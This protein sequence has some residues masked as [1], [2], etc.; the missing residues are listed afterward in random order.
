[1]RTYSLLALFLLGLNQSFTQPAVFIADS[2][3]VINHE[4]EVLAFA[5]GVPHINWGRMQFVD[6]N[7]DGVLELYIGQSNG[8]IRKYNNQGTPTQPLWVLETS[9]YGSLDVGANAAPLWADLDADGDLDMLVGH[10]SNGC[11]GGTIK[12]FENIGDPFLPVWEWVTDTLGGINNCDFST[13]AVADLDDDGDLEIISGGGFGDLDIVMNIGSPQT[14][15]WDTLIIN[16]AFGI[17]VGFKSTPVFWDENNDG[18][19]DL[20]IGNDKGELYF[21]KNIGTPDS[22][23][24]ELITKN[25][26]GVNFGLLDYVAPCIAD[27]DQDGQDE[28]WMTEHYGN[29]NYYKREES[30]WAWITG[31][32]LQPLDVGRNSYCNFADL[33]GDGLLDMVIG[34]INGN[35]RVYFNQGTPTVPNWVLETEA[36]LTIDSNNSQPNFCDLLGGDKVELII[37]DRLGQLNL[38][39]NTSTTNIP[40]WTLTQENILDTLL[41]N[42]GPTTFGDLSGNGKKDLVIGRIDGSILYFVNQSTT[43]S[44]IFVQDTLLFHDFDVGA[45]SFPH[46]SD[47]TLDDKLDILVGHTGTNIL[48]YQYDTLQAQWILDEQTF[49]NIHIESGYGTPFLVKNNDRFDLYSGCWNGGLFHWKSE[50]SIDTL[51]TLVLNLAQNGMAN[52]GDTISIPVTGENFV[53][54]AAISGSISSNE[55]SKMMP[56]GVEAAFLEETLNFFFTEDSTLTIVWYDNEGLGKTTTDTTVLFTIQVVL[57]E[58]AEICPTLHFSETPT[59][60]LATQ[61]QNGNSIEITPLT[62]NYS[63]ICIQVNAPINGEI[64]K[65]NGEPIANVKVSTQT[66]FVVSDFNGHYHFADQI[67][68]QTYE[69]TCEKNEN[70]KNGVTS[71]DI[72]L[73]LKHILGIQPLS[74]TYQ[75]IAADV[76]GQDGITVTDISIITQLILNEIQTFPLESWR[77]VPQDYT[78]TNPSNPFLTMLPEHIMVNLTESI[79]NQDFIGIKVG[80]VSGDAITNVNENST[81]IRFQNTLNFSFNEIITMPNNLSEIHVSAQ[82]F[83]NMTAFELGL[84]W[85]QAVEIVKVIP[86][87]DLESGLFITS[88][89]IDNNLSMIWVDD[90]LKQ[91]GVSIANDQ[92]L[93]KILVK[94]SLKVNQVIDLV[95]L[96]MDNQNN[97]AYDIHNKPYKINLDLGQRSVFRVFPNYPNPF[98]HQTKL[99]FF[100]PQ[101]DVISLRIFDN[102]GQAIFSITKTFEKG[103]Q[104]WLLNENLFPK[105]GIYWFQLLTKNTQHSGKL[106]FI[107]Q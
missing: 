35:I 96:Q 57:L 79:N 95:K 77:F 52:L 59:P 13:P 12:Y 107:N 27:L 63:E 60:I 82:D 100:S 84:S 1:M 92:I 83:K 9:F 94:N 101:Q 2:V 54:I 71:L 102:Q 18:I 42:F 88:I 85:H 29:I 90:D 74:S 61:I 40:Q 103:S 97:V 37:R 30:H 23:S 48:A 91:E 76:N 45:Y 64:M 53:D 33:N 20:L 8:R 32:Y 89:G 68:G 39:Q 78:F 31:D 99:S 62:P 11:N 106:I 38:Y 98:N 58:M 93:F 24:F 7:S 104:E 47:Y 6:L 43:D 75:L 16:R 56:I 87:S 5:G 4:T 14:P 86:H 21:Y 55:P 73:I 25:Y 105:R 80:D 49:A 44:L 66:D 28:L 46:L 17:D 26:A 41:G 34:K 69:L 72:V 10:G 15:I 51:E 67:V 19:I 70:P 22:A 50:S 81:D 36:F 65:E 3:G